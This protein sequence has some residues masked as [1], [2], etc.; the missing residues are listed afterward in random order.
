MPISM[1]CP[2]CNKTLS[3]P[4]SSSGKKA[5]CPACGQ[6]M[7]VPE[8]VREAE[9]VG[10]GGAGASGDLGPTS[11]SPSPAAAGQTRQ[12]CPECGQM[13]V[14]GAAKCRFCNAI[15][16]PTLKL[17]EKSRPGSRCQDLR[18]I[19]S[20]QRGVIFCI[21]FQVLAY[22][23]IFAV[24]QPL[25][26]VPVLLLMI[27]GIAALVFVVLLAIRIYSTGTAILLGILMFIPCVALVTLLVINQAA[28]K[29]LTENGIK[30][31][32]LGASMSQ[33]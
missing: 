4:D 6:I 5:K 24:P 20:Y 15:F 10:V 22:A 18:Q 16:D 21:L 19:A 32:F 23:G 27:A 11:D 3:A 25:A 7:T 33:F 2:S 30:V 14:A 13:I 1:N 28:T 17:L 9:A 12:P 26:F 31:G 29:M 8:V